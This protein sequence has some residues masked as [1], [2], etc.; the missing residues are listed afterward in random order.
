MH[1]IDFLPERIKQHRRQWRQRKRWIVLLLCAI[2]AMVLWGYSGERHISAAEAAVHAQRRQRENLQP[3]LAMIPALT[4]QQASATVKCRISDE[5]GSRL[6]VNAVLAEVARSLP[7][8]AALVELEFRVVKQP[9][10]RSIPTRRSPGGSAAMAT[11]RN[12]VRLLLTG[13]APND[14]DVANFIGKL[15][16]RDIFSDVN[17]HYAQPL[18]IDGDRRSARGFQLSCLLVE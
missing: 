10:I 13:I 5:L 11:P 14:V 3:H 8:S 12:R 15:S 2:A 4:E 9:A 18:K 6:P 17:M 1:E 7:P 16:A